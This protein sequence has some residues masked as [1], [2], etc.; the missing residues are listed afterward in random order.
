MKFNPQK[1]LYYVTAALCALTVAVPVAKAM[2]EEATATVTGAVFEDR[3]KDGVRDADEPGVAGV[4]VSDGQ[5]TV[6]TDESGRYTMTISADRRTNDLVF[7]TQPAGYSVGTD[8][9]MTP[10]FY[11]DL[12]ALADG[13]AVQA[14]FAVLQDKDSRPN[15]S[16]F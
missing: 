14:D 6:A 9:F 15:K 10:R 16:H 2:A 8:E 13:A 11:R 4:A 12:G 1:A 7:I 5:K 3:D